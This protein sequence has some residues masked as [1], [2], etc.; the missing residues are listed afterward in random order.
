MYMFV[1][2]IIIIINIQTQHATLQTIASATLVTQNS[3][4]LSV[5][6]WPA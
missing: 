4:P 2:F 1:I 5:R 3:L 6:A